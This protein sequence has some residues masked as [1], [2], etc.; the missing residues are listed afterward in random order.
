ME[1]MH[2]ILDDCRKDYGEYVQDRRVRIL[3]DKIDT[4]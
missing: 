4:L 3:V 1:D 2:L